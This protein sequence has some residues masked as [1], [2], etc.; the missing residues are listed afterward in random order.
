MINPH[1][2]S[3][4]QLFLAPHVAGFSVRKAAQMVCMSYTAEWASSPSPCASESVASGGKLNTPENVLGKGG[5]A[6]GRVTLVLPGKEGAVGGDDAE[7]V[8]GVDVM[9]S[10]T[11]GQKLLAVLRKKMRLAFA[12]RYV[13]RM[14]HML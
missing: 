1:T 2:R 3:E 8:S 10:R 9:T 12:T 5:G 13:C 7:G 6:E 11:R 14:V 4:L